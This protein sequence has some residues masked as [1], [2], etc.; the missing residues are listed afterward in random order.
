MKDILLVCLS[1]IIWGTFITPL[2]CFGYAIAL[3]GMVWFKL[4]AEKIKSYLAEG[5][6]QWADFGS[7]RPILRKVIVFGGI[8]STIFFLLGGFAPSYDIDIHASQY[9]NAAKNAVGST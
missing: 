7:R 5:G 2:Q 9:I 3:G 1:V 6:R 8:V 4:G